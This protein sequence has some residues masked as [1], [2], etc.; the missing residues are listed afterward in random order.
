MV[1]SEFASRFVDRVHVVGDT[2]RINNTSSN[3][4]IKYIK[5]KQNTTATSNTNQLNDD[6][7]QQ[8][9]TLMN[10]PYPQQYNNDPINTQYNQHQ[11]SNSLINNSNMMHNYDTMSVNTTNHHHNNNNHTINA[12]D[13][14]SIVQQMSNITIQSKPTANKLRD[15]LGDINT[16]KLPAFIQNN[17]QNNHNHML[18][19]SSQQQPMYP[20]QQQYTN[21]QPLQSMPLYNQ[22]AQYSQYQQQPPQSMHNYQLQQQQYQPQFATQP[23]PQQYQYNHLP[24]QSQPQYNNQYQQQQPQDNKFSHPPSS[25]QSLS[26]QQPAYAYNSSQ[27]LSHPTSSR[28]RTSS[29]RSVMSQP[30]YSTSVQHTQSYAAAINTQQLDSLL[31]NNNTNIPQSNKSSSRH[32]R[33][34]NSYASIASKQ[35]SS[36]TQQQPP[37]KYKPYKLSDYHALP[38][39]VTMGSLGPNIDDI[40]LNKLKHINEY[41]QQIRQL[42]T[43][44]LQS[45]KPRVTEP[46]V[47]PPTIHDRIKSYTANIP[48]PK[49]RKYDIRNN[50]ILHDENVQINNIIHSNNNCSNQHRSQIELKSQQIQYEQPVEFTIDDSIDHTSYPHTHSPTSQLLRQHSNDRKLVAAELYRLQ[51]M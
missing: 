44:K 39:H 15:L 21:V 28:H 24:M 1:S 35:S 16:A 41:S 46:V 4:I 50:D 37:P 40:K 26:K 23:Q 8:Q 13:A 3:N 17:N 31:N 30:I 34:S 18:Q 7:L 27:P 25:Q 6:S 2:N 5:T 43:E 42:N 36:N 11:Y 45:V 32:L 9:I 12:A 29:G 49:P 19:P 33:S 20:P 48:K 47:K 51:N 22:Q 38:K 14:H 10:Q